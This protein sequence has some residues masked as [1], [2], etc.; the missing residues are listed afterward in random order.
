[1]QTVPMVKQK[2]HQTLDTLPPQGLKELS[3][4]LD[5]LK[6]KYQAERRTNIVALGGIWQDIP[7]DVTDE[8]VRALRR[9]VTDT[10]LSKV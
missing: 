7:F 10:L 2:V 8:E 5:F 9:R 3:Q 1:M 6:Y 4:F